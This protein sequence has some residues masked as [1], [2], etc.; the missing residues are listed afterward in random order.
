MTKSS[1]HQK[2]PSRAEPP[3]ILLVDDDQE[4][5]RA[6]SSW[7]DSEGF[8]IVPAFDGD[9]AMRII[10][11]HVPDL[12]IADVS[13]PGMNGL[14][15]ANELRPMQIPVLLV[16]A[17]PLPSSAEPGIPFL[18]KPFDLADLTAAIRKLLASRVRN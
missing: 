7:L 17:S 3:Q 9:Q 2:P 11:K 12:V 15:L 8:S 13:M 5:I 10:D 4:L 16:S 6:L 14:A 18:H 1:K